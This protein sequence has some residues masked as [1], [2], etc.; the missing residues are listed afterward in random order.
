MCN[1]QR[2]RNE[3]IKY[4]GSSRCWTAWCWIKSEWLLARK[5]GRIDFLLECKRRRV[6]PRFIQ[7]RIKTGQLLGNRN[8]RVVTSERNF[9]LQILAFV[10]REEFQ[11]RTKLRKITVDQRRNMFCYNR[12]DYL[13]TKNIKEE[14]VQSETME[15]KRR[16]G[17]KLAKLGIDS[18]Q[19]TISTQR[20]RV[21]CI[22]TE[23]N[24][25]ERGLL[26]RGPK[27]VPT[28]DKLTTDDLCTVESAIESTM[29][30]LRWKRED[31]GTKA[32]VE[33]II[34][35]DMI[36]SL[37][38]EPK[39]RSLNNLTQS[40]KQPP[41]MDGESECQ[42]R[43]LKAK[44]MRAY[45]EYHPSQRNI[46]KAEK[47][48]IRALKDR[49]LKEQAIIKCSDKSKS[50]VVLSRDTYIT[51][52]EELLT[53]TESYELTQMSSDRLERRISDEL[54]KVKGLKSLPEGIYKGLFPRDT[55]LPE[56]Y[57]LPKIHKEGTPLR[58]VVAAFDGPLTPVSMLL[59]RIIHQLLKFVPS[60]IENTA[61]AICSLEKTFAERVTE[62]VIVCTMD[63]VA[64]YPSIPIEDGISAVMDKLHQHEDDVDMAGLTL[65]EIRSLLNLVLQN[66]Y[67]KFGDK[68]YRQKKGI[69]MGN[70]LAPPLAIVF[71][72]K[73]EQRMLR[74]AELKPES[75]NRYID[76]CLLVWTHGATNLVKFIDHCNRQHPDIHFTWES[77]A[78]GQPIS[79]MDLK[80]NVEEN[81]RLEYEL[82]QKPS[83]SGVS[84][85]FGSCV[86]RHVKDSVAKQQFRR[87]KALSSNIAARGRSED[88]IRNLLRENG[89]P[90]DVIRSSLEKAGRTSE[91]QMSK[92]KSVVTLHLPFCSDSLDKVVRRLIWKSGLPIRLAYSQAPSLKQMLVRS[93]LVPVGCMIHEKFLEQ[94]QREKK[95]PGKPRDDCISCQAGIKTTECDKK[96]A[97]YLLACNLC[98]E[99]YI[100]ESQRTIRTRLL[101]HQS[102]ARK[103]S[104]DTPWGEHMRKH[105][106]DV[107]VDK[108]PVFRARILAIERNVSNRKAREAIEIRDRRPAINR[109]KGWRLD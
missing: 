23:I 17:R 29:N 99:E 63:V 39:I 32:E 83:D 28:R 24:E 95:R 64:L 58:P 1:L 42:S 7:D 26:E 107:T 59:E 62:G 105:H 84:L 66:N 74:S 51:K 93:A 89:F 100:G 87:A 18:L 40:G 6:I 86:P 53:A 21:T 94:Q 97:I 91:K 31:T 80:I 49:T 46:T 55:R 37:L 14:V 35:E 36:P 38:T 57:G 76:D 45:R 98:S 20:E 27:F 81:N 41:N 71:L 2:V 47:S 48:A 50:L 67:F 68:V 44:I 72:D 101:E 52:A 78:Q 65:V 96:G 8:N 104:K 73:L 85:D 77:T 79:Y 56:F 25:S 102:D 12:E 22:G 15:S 109:N 4:F 33:G 61:A 13:F 54:R 9:G 30:L 70:H 88:K 75:Y 11:K 108:A 106:T 90:E 3:L 82:F 43:D 10:I 103:R 69:A 92:E 5:N 16:L 19:Y 34:E 60:H